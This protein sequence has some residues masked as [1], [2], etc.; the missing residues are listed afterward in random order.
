MARLYCLVWW[1]WCYFGRCFSFQS[2]VVCRDITIISPTTAPDNI[3]LCPCSN[4]KHVNSV[5]SWEIA[6]I[7]FE[8]RHNLMRHACQN[9]TIQ[10]NL[11]LSHVKSLMQLVHL[12]FVIGLKSYGIIPCKFYL[13]CFNI[14]C[15]R[16]STSS[17]IACFLLIVVIYSCL[18]KET[19]RRPQK[20]HRINNLSLSSCRLCD[21]VINEYGG[22]PLSWM[23][24][25][26]VYF[27]NGSLLIDRNDWNR[28]IRYCEISVLDWF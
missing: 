12:C 24:Q 25:P 5:S 15:K 16:S 23:L 27:L 6:Q 2:T 17:V 1:V 3:H 10:R 11:V 28:V 13:K 7:R 19:I 20:F 14:S 9:K 26:E 8:H 22:R 21:W 18:Y 4:V